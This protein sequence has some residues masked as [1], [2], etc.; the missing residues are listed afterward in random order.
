MTRKPLHLIGEPMLDLL[1][2]RSL[3]RA[4]G[5]WAHKQHVGRFAPIAFLLIAAIGS[6]VTFSWLGWDLWFLQ[7]DWDFLLTRG[8][9]PGHSRGW[10]APHGDHWSTGIIAVYRALF[11]IFGLAYPAWAVT[12]VVIHVGVGLAAAALLRRVGCRPWVA[13]ISGAL[14]LFMGSG[15][16]AYLVDNAMNHT[17]SVAL[18]LLAINAGWGR[19]THRSTALTWLLLTTSV[20]FSGT[21]LTM[22]VFAG[23]AFLM[24]HG[25]RGAVRLLAGPAALF[26]YWFVEVGRKG[27]QTLLDPP[28]L[29]LAI[30]KFIW[31]GI[32]NALTQF[33]GVDALGPVLLLILLTIPFLAGA[34][35]AGLARLAVAGWF[36]CAAQFALVGVSRIGFGMDVALVSRYVYLAV[37]LLLPAIALGFELLSEH[38][39]RGGP[40]AALAVS[41]LL[42]GYVVTGVDRSR[43]FAAGQVGLTK[44]WEDRFL[45]IMAAVD[46]GQVVLTPQT[47][48][49]LNSELD[50]ALVTTPE[51]RAA[52]PG[53]APTAEGL[54]DA[55][56]IF[57]TGSRATMFGQPAPQE[58][59]GLSGFS[60]ADDNGIC[61]VFHAVVPGA[62]LRVVSVR[63]AEIGLQG[64][65]GQFRT[66]L[67]RRDVKSN[68]VR[69]W[70]LNVHGSYVATSA[71]N[72]TLLVIL[73]APGDYTVCTAR[74][75]A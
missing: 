72:A 39:R 40:I 15:A 44:P 16:E 28:T 50:P 31:H 25:W 46:A 48:D 11:A 66:Q 22:V 62:V 71:R 49:W 55:E 19:I 59:S 7:D 10:F 73:G 60:S 61:R 58:V 37:I 2:I 6:G 12:T 27:A 74:P 36:G 56:A 17:G 68:I 30:P 45:G 5:S 14:V 69:T 8:T 9:I 43:E 13:A 32:T 63:G 47:E 75:L 33:S 24:T 67:Q 34:R 70:D 54:L 57:F 23:A 35:H 4:A 52:M 51:I 20:A 65:P 41:A 42:L 1:G 3:A 26:A 29:Y 18:G 64:S 38:A 21:G 53:R